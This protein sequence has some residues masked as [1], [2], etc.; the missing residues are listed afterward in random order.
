MFTNHAYQSISISN[1]N[2]ALISDDLSHFIAAQDMFTAEDAA[3]ILSECAEQGTNL[4]F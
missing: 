4:Q 3:R 2:V 1:D